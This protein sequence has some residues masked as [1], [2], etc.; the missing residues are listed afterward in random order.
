M[1]FCSLMSRW[2]LG[3]ALLTSALSLVAQP[4]MATIEGQV[5]GA[6][7]GKPIGNAS[8]ALVPGNISLATA[9]DSSGFYR[10]TA[11]PVGHYV[12]RA[13]AIGFDTL[14]VPELWL[15]AGK[16]SIQRV[17]LS[18]SAN[19]LASV[20]ISAMAK[21][22]P[23]VLGIRTFTV[24]QGL[25]WP[26]TFQDPGR[27]VTALPGVASVNDQANH[28]SIRGNS[29]NANA[30]LL[31]GVE[32]VNLN[33]T[34]NAGT[35]T[36]LPTLSGGGVNM[37]SAQMLGTSRLL[38]GVFP[39]SYDNALGGIL[40]MRFREGSKQ[41]R[42]WTLQA[43]L[44]GLDASTEGPIGT[45]AR[46]SYLVNYR[47]STVGLLGALGVDLGDEAITYQDLSFH[48]A[49][50]IGKR[51]EWHLFGVGGSS[52]NK[53]K[54]VHDTAVWEF[55]KDSRNI[56]YT[57]TTGAIGAR[58]RAPVGA[59]ANLSAAMV[60]SGAY[61]GR[62]EERL[63]PDYAVGYRAEAQLDER[64]LAGHVQ[65]EGA[66]G[67]RFHYEAGASLLERRIEGMRTGV[68]S[69]WMARPWANGRWLLGEHVQA[70]V[71]LGI[72]WFT[73]SETAIAEPRAG[74][75]WHM[76]HGH[77]LGLS[78]GVRSQMPQ[79]QSFSPYSA[80]RVIGPTRSH[81]LVLGYDHPVNDR[82]SVHA[83]AYMQLLTH[84]PIGP[85]MAV[86]NFMVPATWS[87]LNAWDEPIGF[88]LATNGKGRNMGLEASVDHRFANQLFYQANGSLYRSTFTTGD[89]K[90]RDS[91]WDGRY[92]ANFLCGKEFKKAKD[93]RVRTWG[94]SM[95]LCLAGG[96]REQPID[97][98]MSAAIGQTAYATPNWNAPLADLHRLDL[99]IYLKMDREGRTGLWALDL[100]N[101]TNA[102]NEAFRYYDHRKD[103]VVTKY[104]LGIIP[105]IS[106]RIEF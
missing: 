106:Y 90:E 6:T 76:R 22:Q 48:V 37:L 17:E 10:I 34:G 18:A 67:S 80:G 88:P 66:A 56:T 25:R 57:S 81:D 85:I 5:V 11:I 65:L 96:F 38:T 89:I 42:E 59:K 78:A 2:A 35:P 39:I 21:E 97:Q 94:L 27:L 73:F 4:P 9:T 87:V 7:T 70:H 100:Q 50:P 68:A 84:V 13:F 93:D 83:E 51:G 46:S 95:R 26:A 105:N 29:P 69:G 33:H 60:L 55:D 16:Q 72:A 61:Q 14:E 54:A 19:V 86:D 28:L 30:W 52:S 98:R 45:S 103:D 63:L 74:L 23:A 3:L 62:E 20:T 32:V 92:A 8:I 75:Q 49:L 47:Y 36:D 64:K 40:D 31:E 79:W 41:R 101:A 77:V 91:R 43:G 104:Q 15:R 58:M 102:R 82:L 53:F 24:E 1:P 12:L 71:G 99:R 44:M